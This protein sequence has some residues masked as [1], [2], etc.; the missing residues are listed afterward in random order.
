MRIG[1]VVDASCDL[2]HEFMREHRIEILPV[3]IRLGDEILVDV[4]DPQATQ[5]F[6]QE[7]LGSKGLIAET[8]ALTAEQIRERFLDRIVVDY[9]Y[10]FCI[11]ITSTR[12][13]IFENATRASFAILNDYKSIRAQAGVSGPFALRVVDSKNMFCATGVLAAE[14]AKL[15]RAGKAPNDIRK[16]LDD[17]REKLCGYM[18]PGDLYYIRNRGIKKGDKSVSLMTYAI[19]TALDIKP[20]IQSY[21]G[22]TKPV[23]KIL[24]YDRAVERMF[25]HAS[26]QIERGLDTQHLCISYGGDPEA[27]PALPGYA[28]LAQTAREH[29]VEILNSFMSAT[30]A[31]NAG[32]ACV[33]LAFCG[34]LQDFHG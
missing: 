22:E 13:P 27:I 2:P 33:A 9:D 11:T 14:A 19:G 3:T 7:Q 29:G 20:V 4:R 23:A 32:G 6:Y 21:L 17:L 10:I 1:V 18:V 12:S 24:G 16:R 28:Q 34:E 31:V 8:V 30:A 15:A 26:K 5:R 25:G